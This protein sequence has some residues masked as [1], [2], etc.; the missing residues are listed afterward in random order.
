MQKGRLDCKASG[1]LSVPHSHRVMGRFRS[2]SQLS[3]PPPA[4]VRDPRMRSRSKPLNLAD[5]PLTTLTTPL[6]EINETYRFK[7]VTTCHS[8]ARKSLGPPKTQSRNSR[9]QKFLDL[10]KKARI[11]SSTVHRCRMATVLVL[12]RF[13]SCLCALPEPKQFRR[14]TLR[15]E[16]AHT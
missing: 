6:A 8:G 3:S 16:V 12:V 15:A 7:Y 2:R 1:L 14:R 10:E 4:L 5:R 9:K 13:A 11:V